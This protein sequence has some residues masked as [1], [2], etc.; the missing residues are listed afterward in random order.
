[1]EPKQTAPNRKPSSSRL[2]FTDDSSSFPFN[3]GLQL[4]LNTPTLAT[5]SIHLFHLDSSINELVTSSL[6]ELADF[7]SQ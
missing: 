4:H 1:M 3:F 6:M 2:R 5:T 7:T